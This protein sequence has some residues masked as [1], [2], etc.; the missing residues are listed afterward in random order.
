MTT[1]LQVGNHFSD[2]ELANHEN[3]QI[4]LSSLTQASLMDQYLGFLDGYP[5]IVVFY[6]GFF[7][8]RDRQQFTQLVHFQNELMVNYGKLVT[9]C[10]DPPLV[11]AAF[12]AGLG[13]QWQ[14]LCDESRDLIKQINI[15]D[16]TELL[17]RQ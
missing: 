10:V 17:T 16:E 8:P 2:V 13:A 1:N 5:L 14:F 11:Q 9:I 15:L 3:E 12:R 4:K 6:R 7:C